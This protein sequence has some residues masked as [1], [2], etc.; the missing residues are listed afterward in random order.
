M[1]SFIKSPNCAFNVPLAKSAF[2]LAAISNPSDLLK[3]P[4]I[5]LISSG[6]KIL[7]ANA[8]LSS[9]K[10]LTIFLA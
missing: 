2:S 10:S 4:L 8:E 6:V 7:F 3:L 5:F 1:S 9:K